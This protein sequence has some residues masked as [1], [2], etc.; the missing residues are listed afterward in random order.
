MDV[1]IVGAGLA[2]L[3]CAYHLQQAGVKARVLEASDRVG[4]RIGSIRR[5]GFLIDRGFQVLFPHYPSIQALL[6][7]PALSLKAYDAGAIVRSGD[8]FYELADPTR[9]LGAFWRTVQVPF[10]SPRDAFQI[11]RLSLDVASLP[12][13]RLIGGPELPPTDVYL[14]RFGFSTEFI[15]RFMRP[16]FGGVF[17][18]R[19]LQADARIFRFYWK[20]LL[21]GP[22]SVPEAGMQAIPDQLADK[23][24]REHIRHGAKVAALTREDGRV[25]G[26]RLETG[27]EVRADRVVLACAHPEIRRLSGAPRELSGNAAI[28]LYFETPQSLTSSKKVILNAAYDARVNQIAQVTNVNP[29]YAPEGRHLIALQVLGD[30]PGSDEELAFACINEIRGWFPGYDFHAWRLVEAVRTPFGQ[31]REDP[32]TMGSLPG[33]VLGEHLYMASE[34]LVQSSIE[35]ALSGGRLAA[36]IVKGD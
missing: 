25:S 1:L 17:L 26:V 31:F 32:E 5:R 33:P 35:G 23:V 30:Y 27:E 12:V 29:A 15:E 21:L 10:L 34:V 18:N 16:F 4:G 24:G 7:I 6:D 19:D 3:S 8:T 11:A 20:M 22:A 9:H 28:T 2:G 13:D 36:R 14:Q